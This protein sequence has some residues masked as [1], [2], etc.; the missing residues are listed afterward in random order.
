MPVPPE[1]RHGDQL[2]GFAAEEELEQRQ[3][4]PH[5]EHDG[6]VAA[7]LWLDCSVR[8]RAGVLRTPATHQDPV[9][10]EADGYLTI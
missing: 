10:F 5:Q 7:H 2:L 9:Q 8:S 4:A 1:H 3:D 6:Q